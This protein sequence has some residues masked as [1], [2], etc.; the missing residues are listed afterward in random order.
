MQ[1]STIPF[2]LMAVMVAYKIGHPAL[3]PEVSACL[4]SLLQS[5]RRK[6][7]EHPQRLVSP[8]LIISR[9]NVASVQGTIG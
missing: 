6:K 3:E 4:L 8:L 1:S 9:A 2:M 7:V 5:L